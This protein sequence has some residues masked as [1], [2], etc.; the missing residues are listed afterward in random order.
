MFLK[1]VDQ[2]PEL[3]GAYLSATLC[4][5]NDIL[6]DT[7]AL[8]QRMSDEGYLLIR[9]LHNRDHV[10]SARCYILEQLATRGMLQANTDI[11]DAIYNSNYANGAST[12][13]VTNETLSQSEAIT[14]IVNGPRIISFFE[15]F[16]GAAVRNF[17]YRWL[18][19]AGTGASSPI[20]CDNVFMGRGSKNLYTCWTPLCDISFDMGPLV[21]CLN[22]HR[23]EKIT[24]SYGQ[25]DVDR[26][27]IAGHFSEDPV[28]LVDHF[29]GHWAS[30]EFQAGDVVIFNMFML[31]A[32][33]VNSSNRVR[34]SIDTRYQPASEPIAE[35]WVGE[36]PPGHYVWKQVAAEKI[37]PLAESRSRWGI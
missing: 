19:T 4:D 13:A 31:H 26:D 21:L 27:L 6:A 8:H 16:F 30:S 11:A 5:S 22:S 1:F 28:E 25:C 33:L 37:E 17:D 10:L 15:R 20:H 12:T 24:Q 23:I 3:G 32:S 2:E 18:R 36:H 35:R 14:A 29:G 34:I 9:G 7:H